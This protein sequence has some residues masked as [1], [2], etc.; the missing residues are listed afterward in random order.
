[1]KYFFHQNSHTQPTEQS[2]TTLYPSSGWMP[3][4]GQDPFLESYRSTIIHNTLK[5]CKKNNKKQF[6]KKLKK[7]E[8]T[9]ITTL[10]NNKDIVIK[11]A[12]KGGNIVIMNREDYIKEGLRQ[13]SDHNHYELLNEDPTL[14]YN[15]QIHQVLQQAVNLEIID[16]KMKKNTIQ[17]ST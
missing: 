3:P 9:A 15:N 6:K 2:N 12:D 13:L 16:E 17:Q 7:E 8:L 4:S 1:M 5:E 10:R 11:P 14:N